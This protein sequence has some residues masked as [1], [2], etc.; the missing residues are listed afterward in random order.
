M[1]EKRK[2]VIAY[3]TRDGERG[4]ELLVIEIPARPE[5]GAEV[6]AGRLDPGETELEAGLLRE[7]EEETGLTRVRLVGEIAGPDELPGEYENHAFH[8]AC[9][10]AT[11]RSWNHVVQGSGEDAGFVHAC[12]W[13]PL[14][15]APPLWHRADPML[16]RLHESRS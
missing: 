9:D 15:D 4:R 14:D 11:P 5:L 8:V 7:L 12:R 10:D 6:P 1:G 13:V 2:R 16:D 3:V